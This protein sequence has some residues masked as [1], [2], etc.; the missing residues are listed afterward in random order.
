M[1]KDTIAYNL[2]N[3]WIE[4]KKE[5]LLELKE[6]NKSEEKPSEN[7]TPNVQL[8]NGINTRIEENVFPR[9]PISTYQHNVSAPPAQDSSLVLNG[10]FSTGENKNIHYEV[11]NKAYPQI[12]A[13]DTAQQNWQ[14]QANV[15]VVID[16]EKIFVDYCETISSLIKSSFQMTHWGYIP[17]DALNNIINTCDKEYSYDI[18][19]NGDSSFIKITNKSNKTINSILFNIR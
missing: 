15:E 2:L 3:N 7:L 19:N 9:Q 10:V 13:N 11:L 14:G 16:K 17:L 18:I 4:D 8:N 1:E 6:K 5:L 12:R